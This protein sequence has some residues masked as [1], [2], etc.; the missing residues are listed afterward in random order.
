MSEPEA[1]EEA[2]PE[3]GRN[4]FK[5]LLIIVGAMVALLL[6]GI[7]FAVAQ[8]TLRSTQDGTF[9]TAEPVSKIEVDVDRGSVELASDR[10]RGAAL[11]TR[12]EY[13]LRAPDLRASEE[14]GVV[15]VGADC[16]WPSDC[17][18]DVQGRVERGADV[19]IRTSS[20]RTA[21]VGSPGAVSIRTTDGAILVEDAEGDVN[22]GS[23]SGALT[24]ERARRAVRAESRSGVVSGRDLAGPLRVRTLTGFVVG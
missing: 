5:A 19:T 7:L 20:G 15:D 24:V 4:R 21:V 6:L 16:D 13:F 8:F 10:P 11:T 22:V 17:E 23:L 12:L 1:L 9:A 3:Q 14:G 18:I 2:V